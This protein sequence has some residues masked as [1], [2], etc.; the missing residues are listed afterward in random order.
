MRISPG[1]LRINSFVDSADRPSLIIVFADCL[2][3]WNGGI[4]HVSSTALSKPITLEEALRPA[5]AYHHFY[6]N[7]SITHV[8]LWE[9]R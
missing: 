9:Y 7:N 2:H 5:A 4:R 3:I 8:S 1:E 6:I